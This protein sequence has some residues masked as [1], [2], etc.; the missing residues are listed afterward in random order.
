MRTIDPQCEELARY[1]T[2]EYDFVTEE[3]VK[4]L[5]RH[6]QGSIK[7]WMQNVEFEKDAAR[8]DAAD[9]AAGI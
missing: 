3:Q 1:M 8:Q 5:A 9:R 4:D 6:I 7:D 2:S